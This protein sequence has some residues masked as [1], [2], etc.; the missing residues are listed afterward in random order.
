MSRPKMLKERDGLNPGPYVLA[1]ESP[2]AAWCGGFQTGWEARG[3]QQEEKRVMCPFC[4]LINA[5]AFGNSGVYRVE[6]NVCGIVGPRS[7]TE[8]G[9][10]QAW[11]KRHG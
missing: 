4:G 8:D 9:A 5:S 1:R 11:G 2:T 3:E 6:C 7:S 10:W